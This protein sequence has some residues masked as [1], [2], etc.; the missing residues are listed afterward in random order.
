[1]PKEVGS[2]RQI[3]FFLLSLMADL[4]HSAGAGSLLGG[5]GAAGGGGGRVAGGALQPSRGQT[6]GP[7]P[8][9]LSGTRVSKEQGGAMRPQQLRW[10]KLTESITLALAAVDLRAYE[11]WSSGDEPQG[12]K[13]ALMRAEGRWVMTGRLQQTLL[14]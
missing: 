9:T 11:G 3:P 1:M 12:S 10:V 5:N 13:P 14:C 2:S 6:R 4:Y 7:Q 8:E